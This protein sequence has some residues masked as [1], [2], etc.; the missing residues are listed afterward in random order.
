MEPEGV[1]D[2]FSHARRLTGPERQGYLDGLDSSLRAEVS[3]LLKHHA[4][5]AGGDWKPAWNGSAAQVWEGAGNPPVID[6]F[7]VLGAIGA[8][9][10]GTV[11]EAE[12][13]QPRR[14]VAIKLLHL[15]SEE[16]RRRFDREA[17][18]LASLEHPFIARIHAQG[19]VETAAG[20]QPYLVMERVDG[21]DLLEASRALDKR[22]RVEL[23]LHVCEAVGHAHE[24]GVIHRD[25][26]PANVLVTAAGEPKVLDFGLARVLGG[27]SMQTVTG[28]VLGT[29]AY[30]SP[31]QAMGVPGAVDTRSDVYSLGVMGYEL[32]CGKPPLDLS[33]KSLPAVA[34]ALLED[35]PA[36][37][38]GSGDLPVVLGMALA[39]EKERRYSSAGAL[40]DDLRRVLAHE[41]VV[42]RPGSATYQIRRFV[43]RNSALVAGV[44][45]TVI[46]LSVGLVVALR[47]A[48]EARREE[49][50]ARHKAALASIQAAAA[51]GASGSLRGLKYHLKRVPADERGW[52]WNYL[53]HSLD[54]ST[55]R[56]AVDGRLVH[57]ALSADG[58]RALVSRWGQSRQLFGF[59]PAEE[60]KDGDD[61]W[62][63]NWRNAHCFAGPVAHYFGSDGTELVW[64]DS[65]GRTTR[66]PMGSTSD[67]I[68]AARGSSDG[69]WIAWTER[70]R[71]VG[72]RV[73]LWSV[74]ARQL[75][76]EMT[77]PASYGVCMT[78]REDGRAFAVGTLDGRVFVFDVESAEPT[79]AIRPHTQPVT[80]LALHPDGSV[81][82]SAA[83]A[84]PIEIRDVKS[85]KPRAR[86][87]GHHAT[88]VS[89]AYSVQGDRLASG[90]QDH[91][92]R[93][94]DCAAGN[95]ERILFGPR[96]A[97]VALRFRPDGSQ[98]VSGGGGAIHEWDLAN[99]Q[100]LRLHDSL[101]EGN[102]S[103]YVYGVAISPDG[104][105]LASCGWD[106][107]GRL[108]D[109]RTGRALKT[110]R[111]D[112][113]LY[114]IAFSPDSR[115]I[116]TARKHIELWDVATGERKAKWARSPDCHGLAFSPDGKRL[117]ASTIDGVGI[118]DVDSG[119]RTATWKQQHSPLPRIDWSP[120][121][122]LL[123]HTGS[124]KSLLIRNADDGTVQHKLRARRANAVAFSPDS[125]RV[126]AG[127][128]DSVVRV[129]DVATGALVHE[130]R[131]HAA[132]VYAVEYAPD[133]S[134]IASGSADSTVRIWD[135]VNGE[136][137]LTLRG[138][139]HYVMDLAFS[140][141]GKTLASA[142]GDN[143][144]R[145]WRSGN[146]G[147]GD[148]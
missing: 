74:P 83:T 106:K 63:L 13:H 30:M 43:R 41:T 143:T 122:K 129:W 29:M 135:A 98:L 73:R 50:R 113:P 47:F 111:S 40:A 117:A 137:R 95:C 94:W 22:A 35:D 36:P 45:A 132:R 23:L 125:R 37:L 140:S 131:G 24:H 28:H 79:L 33:D 100:V 139:E 148:E 103:P 53:H 114:A 112:L 99:A 38:P 104:S 44:A 11:F 91:S 121:G 75:A 60:P 116:A 81:V 76:W 59:G 8:G 39:K 92:I 126:A 128:A 4:A 51:A 56:V 127:C 18:V 10:M 147:S 90:S 134:R 26:K 123:A 84:L 80:A 78:F 3:E 145:L 5:Y 62:Q 68:K 21:V 64:R 115:T 82:A 85:G 118:W 105:L 19:V 124:G 119:R 109:A 14:R 52:E 110:L 6:G 31:E 66:M 130:L 138:H 87:T 146:S 17:R 9:G 1:Y 77:L 72:S 55:L 141:D 136:E 144:V 27:D 65:T 142:S 42:A 46:A 16:A 32:M 101:A 97:A 34:R 93:I 20:G 107:T 120:D 49:L 67:H 86:L 7:T 108:A 2:A 54:S 133:G 15:A 57:V 61:T 89:L 88:V 71:G 69:K 96:G 25:L 48:A 12:Q 58:D 102:P 70:A